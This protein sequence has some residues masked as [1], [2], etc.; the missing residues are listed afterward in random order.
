MRYYWIGIGASQLCHSPYRPAVR[1]P[2][3]ARQ[4]C[5]DHRQDL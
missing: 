3:P 2:E 4:T 5:A 1:Q